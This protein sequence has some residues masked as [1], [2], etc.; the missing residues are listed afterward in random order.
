MRIVIKRRIAQWVLALIN[1]QLEPVR[2]EL[3][4][5]SREAEMAHH[6]VGL[7]NIRT[8]HVE[9]YLGL[10]HHKFKRGEQQWKF[11]QIASDVARGLKPTQ[12][13]TR[14]AA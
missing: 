3:K 9:H 11:N 7:A 2:E 14:K 8:Q 6:R 4:R 13:F 10:R 5:L 12:I 1:E